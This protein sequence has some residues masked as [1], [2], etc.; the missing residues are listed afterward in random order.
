[1]I[2]HMRHAHA[3]CTCAMHMRHAHAPCTFAMHM[4]HTNAPCTCAMHMRHAH[5]PCT[6]AMHMRHAH[7]PCTCAMHMRHASPPRLMA[8]E[9][10]RGTD[11]RE[12]YATPFARIG[13]TPPR[14]CLHAGFTTPWLLLWASVAF[15]LRLAPQ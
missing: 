15:L 2:G 14:S 6:C 13:M 10:I 9:L 11:S 5:A 3:P 4:R 8:S 12:S 7:A 1:M